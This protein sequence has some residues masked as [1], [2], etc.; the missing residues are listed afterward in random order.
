MEEGNKALSKESA[1]SV[2]FSHRKM[3]NGG[4]HL[5]REFTE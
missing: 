2:F 4:C 1:Q 5:P 3:Q